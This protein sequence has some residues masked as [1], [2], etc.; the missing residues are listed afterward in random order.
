M[1]INHFVDDVHCRAFSITDTSPFNSVGSVWYMA[2]K[3]R[4]TVCRQR[5]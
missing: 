3:A 1:G 2:E 5:A 4:I